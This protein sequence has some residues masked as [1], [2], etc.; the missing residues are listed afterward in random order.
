ML[1]RFY[2]NCLD[3]TQIDSLGLSPLA[4]LLEVIN[5]YKNQS[6]TL[7]AVLATFHSVG[8]GS[9]FNLYTDLDIY[10]PSRVLLSVDQGGMTLPSKD[11][12]YADRYDQVR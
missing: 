1:G 8:V 7:E 12:Y 3:Q 5:I 2:Q 4:S 10:N 6:S 11:Y 9:L